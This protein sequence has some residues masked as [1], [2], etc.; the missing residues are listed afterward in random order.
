M[1]HSANLGKTFDTQ[2]WIRI[3][4]GRRGKHRSDSNIVHGQ[5][6]GFERLLQVV[7]RKTQ[8]LALSQ[9]LPRC[10]RGHICLP[11]V[12]AGGRSQPCDIG[13][14]INNDSRAGRGQPEDPFNL[15]QQ[16]TRIGGFVPNLEKSNAALE[17]SACSFDGI[18]K[19][20]IRDRVE[21]RKRIHARL[22]LPRL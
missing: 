2:Y 9:D 7:G 8:Q 18:G 10:S 19:G 13:T 21:T 22:G 15:V 17:E 6:I 5:M 16:L 12:G 1:N 4:F 20:S 3:Q 11:E 14:V